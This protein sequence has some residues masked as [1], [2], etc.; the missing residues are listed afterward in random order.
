MQSEAMAMRRLLEQMN[1]DF[2]Q[3]LECVA[4]VKAIQEQY[5]Y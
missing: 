4:A 2:Q 5:D 1:K 3:N